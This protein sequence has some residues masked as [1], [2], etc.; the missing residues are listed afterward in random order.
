MTNLCFPWPV[1]GEEALRFA[2]DMPSELRE[3]SEKERARKYKGSVILLDY[4]TIGANRPETP[5]TV[6]D[7]EHLSHVSPGNE[8]LPQLSQNFTN[9]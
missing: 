8:N 7:L 5:G 2:E 4:N 1:N 9:A 3:E 6:P